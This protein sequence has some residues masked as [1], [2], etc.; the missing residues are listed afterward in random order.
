MTA[1]AVAAGMLFAAGAAAF[2]LSL[3]R[4]PA[5]G[6]E[7]PGGDTATAAGRLPSPHDKPDRS[8]AGRAAR[9]RAAQAAAGLAGFAAGYA[10]SG[11]WGIALLGGGAGVLGPPFAAAPAR[12]RRHTALALAWQ[13]WA[14][15]LAELARSGAGLADALAASAAHAP[16]RIASV[17]SDTART[18]REHGIGAAAERL[19]AAGDTFEPDIAAGLA[20]AA[21]AGGPVAASLDMLAAR[22]GDS[23]ATHRARTEAVIAL[24][25]QTIALLGL[26]AAVITLMYRNNPAYFDPYRTPAG[27]TFLVL[28]AMVLLAA[29]AF[30]V[31]H[32]TVRTARSPLAPPRPARRER[33]QRRPL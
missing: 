22:I 6:T 21:G 32:S 13:A 14:R 5:A 7:P 26:A 12:R 1:S 28:I 11:L 19:A 15:Q 10:V 25:T 31:R 3:R 16:P 17:V 9:L 24:W 4:A 27:Q 23:V 30:L 8:A 2:A 18:A 33:P 20:T 29:S